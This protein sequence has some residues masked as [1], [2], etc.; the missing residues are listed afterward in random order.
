MR[1]SQLLG[2]EG[3][4]ENSMDAVSTGDFILGRCWPT[5][6]WILMVG[7]RAVWPRSW[8]SGGPPS[9]NYLELDNLYASTSS[10]MPQKKNP[11]HGGAGR[12]QDGLGLGKLMAALSIC[13]GLPLSYNRDLQ[14]VT[15]RPTSGGEWTGQEARCA[16]WTAASPLSS[17]WNDWRKV[18]APAFPATQIADSLV[19]INRYALSHGAQHCG[20][21]C[22]FGQ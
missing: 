1:T 8:G 21:D 10:I 15:S 2:F 4:A 16:F 5:S 6:S 13:K 18:L 11:G 9:S 14:E 17:T 19:R 22:R 3:L 12:R 7:T 20:P